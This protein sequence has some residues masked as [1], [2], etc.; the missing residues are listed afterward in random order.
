[1]RG[2]VVTQSIERDLIRYRIEKRL[3]GR[4]DLALHLLVYVAV[5]AFVALNV[6]E[7]A[8]DGVVMLGGMWTIPLVLHGMR[9]YYRSGPGAVKRAD[10][11]ERAIEEQS[12]RTALDEDEE[13]L[14]EERASKRVAARRILVAH[15]VTSAMMFALVWHSVSAYGRYTADDML[16]MERL[17][18]IAVGIFALHGMRFFFVHGKTPPGRAL[19][20]DAELER[21]W[22]RAREARRDELMSGEADGHETKESL[23]LGTL[24]GRR[25]RLT[26]EGEFEDEIVQDSEESMMYGGSRRGG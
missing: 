2:N 9:Y 25:L 11:I 12:S 3:S 17:A 4:R 8:P 22:L 5:A 20:I 14:I 19:K 21:L 13:L 1:M 26:P 23:G 18:Q 7:M 16:A 24:E 6:A 10:E 15:G